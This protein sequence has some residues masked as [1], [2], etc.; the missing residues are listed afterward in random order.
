[1]SC[2]LNF[3]FGMT[4]MAFGA[5]GLFFIKFWKKTHDRLF[6]LFALAFMTLAVDRIALT[7]VSGNGEVTPLV[8][9]L[10]LAAFV[11]IFLAVIDKNRAK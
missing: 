1:M 9:V 8:Y 2:A 7:L 5:S 10:R 6:L 11:L 4:A 3:I